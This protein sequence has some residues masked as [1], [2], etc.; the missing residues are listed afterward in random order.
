MNTNKIRVTFLIARSRI[1]QAGKC[2]IRCRIT[3]L[4]RRHEFATGLFI[5]PNN[6]F[7]KEQLAKP[8]DR[9]ENRYINSQLSLIKNKINQV[10]LLLQYSNDTFD[11]E[12]IYLTYKGENIKKDKTLLELFELHNSKMLKL[13]GIQYARKYYLKFTETENTLKGFLQSFYKKKDFYLK[14]L[15]L[16]FLDD[17]DY[18]LKSR[19]K[20]LKQISINKNIQRLRKIIKLAISEGFIQTDPFILYKPKRVVKEIVFLTPDELSMLENFKFKQD[21]LEQ[22]KDMFIFCCYS[23]LAY[24]EMSS[25]T[26]KSI[27]VGFDGNLWIDIYR[28]KT[29]KQFSVPLLDKAKNILKKY[30]GQLDNKDI[31]PSISNQKFNSYLKEIAE[32]VGIDKKLTH[33]IARKTFATTV[34][35]YND[36]P[37]EIV[38]ELLGHSKISVTQEHYAKVVSKKVS[39]HISKLGKKL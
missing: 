21:R 32:I 36:V 28:Q 9:D 39:E 34:L 6:W 12:D 1:N 10:F 27:I 20:N 13:V 15:S 14:K 17:Y 2:S 3:F 30:E 33:H 4:K 26:K 8:P 24:L 29:K 23:G 19:K 35:L 11:V 18:Y 5:K 37:I 38:S 22:V 25:L 7:S 16:K 31:L